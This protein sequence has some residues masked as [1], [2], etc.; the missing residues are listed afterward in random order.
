MDIGKHYRYDYKGIRLDPY[1]I[2]RVYGITDPAK[3]HCIKKLLRGG[4][5]HKSE[6]DDTLEAMAI[7]ERWLEMENEDAQ[8]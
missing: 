2:F 3:Q 4:N 6:R 8:S 7:L 5:G 1:R